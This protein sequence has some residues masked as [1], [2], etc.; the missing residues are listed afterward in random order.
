MN[1]K[2]M[3]TYEQIEKFKE[4]VTRLEI[5]M[6]LLDM[7]NGV[8]PILLGPYST[9]SEAHANRDNLWAFGAMYGRYLWLIH[10]ANLRLLYSVKDKIEHVEIGIDTGPME[11][12]S[13][14][15]KVKGKNTWM[16]LP[17]I[18]IKV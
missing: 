1:Y 6:Y 15:L 8:D 14:R 18:K 10:P 4:S 11:V 7:A 17:K 9:A 12:V 2:T 5:G 13:A 16:T 3:L